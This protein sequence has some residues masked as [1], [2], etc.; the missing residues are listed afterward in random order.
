MFLILRHKI[1]QK[2]FIYKPLSLKAAFLTHFKHSGN[3][4]NIFC[5]N[6]SSCSKQHFQP[7]QNHVH[8]QLQ[9]LRTLE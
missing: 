9:Y 5:E 3:S 2:T 4:K 7:K 1:T 6:H 8:Y